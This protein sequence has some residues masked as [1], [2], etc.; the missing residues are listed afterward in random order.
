MT[1]K[2]DEARIRQETAAA[3]AA[4]AGPAPQPLDERAGELR[5]L[6]GVEDVRLTACR[7]SGRAST[8]PL[9]AAMNRSRSSRV[10]AR[11]GTLIF[12]GKA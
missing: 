5:A 4:Y 11:E 10:K 2:V 9:Q 1:R 3:I 12:V 6:I 8:W 7:K